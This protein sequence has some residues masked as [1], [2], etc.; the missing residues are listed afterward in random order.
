MLLNNDTVVSS[1][2][3]EKLVKTA[4]G[5][6]NI[7][8]VG[9]K[10]YY[11]DSKKIWFGGGKFISWRASGKHKFWLQK[12]KGQK[13]YKG[14]HKSDFITGCAMLIKSKVFEDIGFLYKP[15]FLTFED[16]D[17]CIRAKKK[18]WD[19]FVNLNSYIW[20][21]V[22]FSRGGEFSF[23]NGYYGTRNRL[24]FAFKRHSI[25]SGIIVL[26]LILPIRIIQWSFGKHDL[27]KGAILGIIDFLKGK[28]GPKKLFLCFLI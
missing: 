3:L 27:L 7:G 10:I 14:V 22:G 2:F 8:I 28:M 21:K 6:E 26:F 11:E 5:D 20:H 12:D 24:F 25:L 18:G 16:L 15:Y 23:S 1:G 9:P 19:I 13:K 4:Q 17:F